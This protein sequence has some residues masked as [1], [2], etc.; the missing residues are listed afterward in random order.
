MT[1]LAILAAALLALLAL[2]VIDLVERHARQASIEDR[3]NR[4]RW[5]ADTNNGSK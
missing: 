3:I 5:P 2:V 4:R 1:A